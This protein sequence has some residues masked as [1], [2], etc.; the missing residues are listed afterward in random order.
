[1]SDG[2]RRRGRGIKRKRKE[3]KGREISCTSTNR[4]TRLYGR[5]EQPI[6][7]CPMNEQSK[8]SSIRGGKR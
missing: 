5:E 4:I 7:R 6:I 1:M 8:R 3:E 2:D